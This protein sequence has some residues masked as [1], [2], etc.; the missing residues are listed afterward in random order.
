[1]RPLRQYLTPKF[2]YYVKTSIGAMS[3]PRAN[4]SGRAFAHSS[5]RVA[6]P[7]RLKVA[8]L[9]SSTANCKRSQRWMNDSRGEDHPPRHDHSSSIATAIDARKPWSNV[10][11]LCG[12]PFR[13]RGDQRSNPVE[14]YHEYNRRQCWYAVLNPAGGRICI[15]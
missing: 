5:G 2:R 1:M 12:R 9:D 13:N 4:R 7:E 6:R 10:R 11:A 14:N 3:L 15:V 8:C